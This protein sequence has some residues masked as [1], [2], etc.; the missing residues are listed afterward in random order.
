MIATLYLAGAVV[1][2]GGSR[3]TGK[4]AFLMISLAAIGMLIFVGAVTTADSI[5]KERREGTLDLLFLT[6]LQSHS[7]VRAKFVSRLVQVASAGM[8][9]LP[10]IAVTLLMGGVSQAALLGMLLAL[11]AAVVT[12]LAAGLTASSFCRQAL[13]ATVLGLMFATAGTWVQWYF[14]GLQ[15]AWAGVSETMFNVM[16]ATNLV[17]ALIG[18]YVAL[19]LTAAKIR[20][21]RNEEG[22]SERRRWFRTVFLTPR[23]WKDYFRRSM[24]RR[25]ERNPLVWLEYRSA[26]RRSARWM[27]VLAL[28]TAET[29]VV[30]IS[31]RTGDLMLFQAL[32]GLVITLFVGVTSAGSFKVE[33]E[34][35]AFELLLVAPLKE[36][37]I[38]FDRIKA[39]WAYYKPLFLTWA[40]FLW[41]VAVNFPYASFLQLGSVIGGTL[42]STLLSMYTL[43]LAGL[44]FAMRLKN[45]LSILLATLLTGAILPLFGWMWMKGAFSYLVWGTS[46]F[47]A[48]EGF[49]YELAILA[50]HVVLW[51][52]LHANVYGL[53]KGREFA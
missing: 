11:I 28:V 5:S 3:G 47:Y 16:L 12:G 39:V 50:T 4:G 20:A 2:S 26:W 27:L 30:M 19:G 24:G 13:P 35:G 43:P 18:S 8:V 10:I 22:E 7:I 17:L 23:Y 48:L 6:M 37:A 29:H 53:L 38:I 51:V 1:Q 21:K 46:G 9:L 33:K 31:T 42:L 14:L 44:Y 36:E 32:L 49:P 15:G 34:S 40:A 52:K 41:F 45:Y 25:L